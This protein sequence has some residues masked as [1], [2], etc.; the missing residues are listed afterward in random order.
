[1]NKRQ[2]TSGP[3]LANIEMET[4]AYTNA[5]PVAIEGSRCQSIGYGIMPA[6]GRDGDTKK[7]I[8]SHLTI[9]ENGKGKYSSLQDTVKKIPP[10][11]AAAFNK[12]TRAFATE[13][14]ALRACAACADAF[15]GYVLKSEA[16]KIDKMKAAGQWDIS[17]AEKKEAAKISPAEYGRNIAEKT[18][19]KYDGT[20]RIDCVNAIIS[21][22]AG[23]NK[24]LSDKLACVPAL[25]SAVFSAPSVGY[26]IIEA[27]I[28]D[29]VGKIQE[30]A[31]ADVK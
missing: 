20:A 14:D 17:T 22:I 16:E 3:A 24:A 30:A 1:M 9:K 25:V 18:A 19:K 7:W 23:D 6:T 2:N 27:I 11:Y 29:A 5:A 15:R 28:R 26:D 4:P 8:I 13:A 12:Y 31:A 21:D 10:A